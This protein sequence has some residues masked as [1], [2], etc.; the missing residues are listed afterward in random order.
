MR[1]FL[2][3]RIIKAA[4][5]VMGAIAPLVPVFTLPGLLLVVL[6]GEVA[7]IGTVYDEY[8]LIQ[9]VRQDRELRSGNW[10]DTQSATE[11]ARILSHD[12]HGSMKDYSR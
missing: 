9:Y 7:L 6:P 12:S 10:Q 11:L 4:L 8:Q 3:T 2:K 1:Q 5:G